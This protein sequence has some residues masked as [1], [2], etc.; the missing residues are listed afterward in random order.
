MQYISY[1]GE[2]FIDNTDIN[3]GP[4]IGLS[5][6]DKNRVLTAD[7][8]ANI[9]IYERNNNIWK[10]DRKISLKS[11]KELT[12]S[13]FSADESYMCLYSG[14]TDSIYM[15][16]NSDK[17]ELILKLYTD[18]TDFNREVTDIDLDTGYIYLIDT[19]NRVILLI[20][21]KRNMKLNLFLIPVLLLDQ[22]L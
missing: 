21:G 6:I 13:A 20:T 7:R 18:D 5:L 16:R 17:P 10:E 9:K 14:I 4:I 2:S 3:K 22:F 12:F 11:E 15:Y 19:E 8:D 1:I